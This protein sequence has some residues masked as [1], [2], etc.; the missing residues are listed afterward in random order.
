MMDINEIRYYLPHRYPFLFLDR[1][2]ELKLGESIV[3]IKNITINEPIF[4]RHFPGNPI[5]PG[6]CIIEAMAQASGVL[7]LKTLGRSPNA[8][9]ACVIAGVDKVRFKQPTVP[10]DQLEIR[11]E[12]LSRKRSI[13]KFKTEARVDG[14]VVGSA[15]IL[16]AERD[17]ND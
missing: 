12:I 17:L 6:V 9:T 5:F 1:V 7:A 2:T 4:D 16:C 11:S 14:K 15:E 8:N 10:G 3:A 13:W